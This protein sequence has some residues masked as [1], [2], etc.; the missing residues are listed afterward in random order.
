MDDFLPY[1]RKTLTYIAKFTK[2]NL[3]IFYGLYAIFD[4]DQIL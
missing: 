1:V 2:V 4:K 3:A